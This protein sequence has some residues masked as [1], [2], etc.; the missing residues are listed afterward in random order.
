M[1]NQLDGFAAMPQPT[2]NVNES[3]TI[4]LFGIVNDIHGIKSHKIMH[5]LVFYHGQLEYQR[6]SSHSNTLQCRL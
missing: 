5:T 6:V 3:R 1:L 4:L 2:K